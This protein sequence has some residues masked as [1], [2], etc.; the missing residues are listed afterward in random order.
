MADADYPFVPMKRM[1]LPGSSTPS[2]GGSISV[3]PWTL[4]SA[5]E[6]WDGR[7][8]MSDQWRPMLANFY[9]AFLV[10]HGARAHIL[11]TEQKIATC[12]YLDD[13]VPANE[14]QNTEGQDAPRV[15]WAMRSSRPFEPLAI[16][17]HRRRV[18][19]LDVTENKFV[20][21]LCGHGGPIT[22]IAVHPTSPSIFATTSRDFTTRIYNLDLAQQENV[23]N[24]TW[25]PWVGPSQASA[26]HGMY[27]SVSEQSGLGRCV[28]VLVGGRSGGHHWDVLGAA[29]HPRLPLIATCGM[30]RH[31]K[32]WWINS[33]GDTMA[34]EDK[35]LFSAIRGSRV[36][37]IAWLADDVLL[38]HTA[39]T[40]LRVHGE[41]S[42]YTE[43]GTLDV[44]QWLGLK[45]FFPHD[46][47]GPI[48]RGGASV[49]L[50]STLT[51]HP[52]SLG[53]F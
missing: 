52:P 40:R 25:L 28:Q 38:T 49:R 3:F 2:D 37:S 29:F 16:L 32:I 14:G 33:S 42:C 50:N 36:L 30:D 47:P 18:L 39:S 4:D 7:W 13:A 26:A 24:P 15:A 43:Q 34:R 20:G 41:R 6:L 8:R 19:V 48:L 53:F 1:R 9:D 5:T 23:K 10:A 11:H 27:M 17:T 51:T 44:W 31:V 46:D 21:Y 22:S 35:P 45:R 12:I